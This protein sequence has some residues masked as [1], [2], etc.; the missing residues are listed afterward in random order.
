MS[1]RRLGVAVAVLGG[2]LYAVGGSDGTSPLN[3]VERYNPQEN[4]WHTIAPMGTRRKHLGCAVYQDMIY[5]VGG[6]DDTTELS[7]A[8]RYNPR[9]NQWSPV[10]AMTSRRS[11]VSARLLKTLKSKSTKRGLCRR[12]LICKVGLAV[13]NGQLMAVGGFDGTTYL[14]TIEVFDPD[15]NTWRLYGG[16]NYRRLGGGV[17]VIK[18][19]HC[20]SHIW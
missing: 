19:T 3:T 17:G 4:R 5:A 18:M 1:T 12:S 10:V 6:R 11:G 15:A 9:T 7:S 16:M 2:F 14:K 20:E 8:E 13:V